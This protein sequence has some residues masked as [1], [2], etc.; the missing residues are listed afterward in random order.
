MTLPRPIDFD[1]NKVVLNMARRLLSRVYVMRKNRSD[2]EVRSAEK[3]LEEI[4]IE[5]KELM[6]D[7][8][9]RERFSQWK[10]LSDESLKI[11]EFL[12]GKEESQ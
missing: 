3:R 4:Q 9:D 6:V 7:S 2:E 8:D 10:V 5:I 12:D 1:N 11:Q